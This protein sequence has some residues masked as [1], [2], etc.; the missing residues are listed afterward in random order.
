M[1]NP[2]NPHSEPRLFHTAQ[3]RYAGCARFAALVA[4]GFALSSCDKPTPQKTDSATTN[5]SPAPLASPSSTTSASGKT[6]APTPA[7]SA[8]AAEKPLGDSAFV[9]TWEG[10][11]NAKKGD[12]GMPPRVEDK[13]RS[14]D[15]G[16]MA[17]GAGT[18]V[19][20]IRDTMEL[21]GTS[22]GALGNAKLRGKVEGDDVRAAFDP[23]DVQDKHGMYGMV[24]GKR[25]DDRIE[26][27]IRV[28]SG[29]ATVV[30]EAEVVLKRKP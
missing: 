19:I 15:D 12:V 29:D 8:S 17:I 26:L 28:A 24:S 10:R 9:G 30:R 25:K 3:R 20:T 7:P 23:V 22:E 1:P 21:E 18:L 14:K 13:V 16:K 4:F 5:A 6:P 11:Y 2:L 27:L